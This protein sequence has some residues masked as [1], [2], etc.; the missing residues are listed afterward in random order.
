MSIEKCCPPGH[1][2]N[3]LTH[4]SFWFKNLLQ[5]IK[6]S[7]KSLKI[8]RLPFPTRHSCT[9]QGPRCVQQSQPHSE[10]ATQELTHVWIHMPFPLPTC[11][12]GVLHPTMPRRAYMPSIHSARAGLHASCTERAR[13]GVMHGKAHNRGAHC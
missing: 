4:I 11:L 12:A 1:V 10:P 13:A 3:H 2:R 8:Q 5:F 7:N 9:D 6:V